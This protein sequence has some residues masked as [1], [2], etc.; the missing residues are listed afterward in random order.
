MSCFK[1]V[2]CVRIE[3]YKCHV[4]ATTIRYKACSGKKQCEGGGKRNYENER[5]KKR[6]K[7]R[8]KDRKKERKREEERGRKM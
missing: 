4:I 8:K 6:K 2:G 1:R 5:N 3:K 7:L